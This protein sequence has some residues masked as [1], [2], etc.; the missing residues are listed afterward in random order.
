MTCTA[1]QT[2]FLS[3][4]K[5]SGI[6]SSILGLK[7]NYQVLDELQNIW[8]TERVDVNVRQQAVMCKG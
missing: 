3:Y 2:I 5:W 8:N 6:S 7:L 4:N 1:K